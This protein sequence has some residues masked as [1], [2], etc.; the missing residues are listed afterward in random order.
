MATQPCR[1]VRTRMIVY[2]YEQE[3]NKLIDTETHGLGHIP[4]AALWQEIAMNFSPRARKCLS[5]YGQVGA[6]EV[7][8][9]FKQSGRCFDAGNVTY[10]LLYWYLLTHSD[11][12]LTPWIYKVQDLVKRGDCFEM[13]MGIVWIRKNIDTN[14]RWGNSHQGF[15]QMLT[16]DR[17]A[18]TYMPEAEEAWHIMDLYA[19]ELVP[20]IP[21]IEKAIHAMTELQLLHSVLRPTNAQYNED[22]GLVFC[23]Y[24]AIRVGYA[25]GTAF[26]ETNVKPLHWRKLKELW[27]RIPR[28]IQSHL[29]ENVQFIL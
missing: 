20:F 1:R 26:H 5:H 28:H 13:T 14:K 3:M 19:D 17:I 6:L 16:D 23:H 24:D 10:G 12:R 8:L 18:W 29:S 15:C 21:V 4:L 25:N 27:Y 22:P 2:E 9:R 11:P 7:G